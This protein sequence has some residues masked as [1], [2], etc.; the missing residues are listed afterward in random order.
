VYTFHST[1][2]RSVVC[3]FVLNTFTH[4]YIHIYIQVCLYT[5][6]HTCIRI[7]TR[8]HTYIYIFTCIYI[9][10]YTHTHTHTHTYI[11]TYIHR[12][13]HI[14]LDVR[15]SILIH[16]IQVPAAFEYLQ[17]Y[18]GSLANLIRLA[19]SL[20][21][22]TLAGKPCRGIYIRD[23]EEASRVLQ[24]SVGKLDMSIYMCVCVYI[25]IV[26]CSYKYIKLHTY[27]YLCMYTFV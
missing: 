6:I 20:P 21:Q 26:I 25:Y 12:C 22:R 7:H 8:I 15:S 18:N 13:I 9:Y 10:T 1:I 11:H 24:T 23:A 3:G 5:Y 19:V 2:F 4:A 14:H 27:M 16:N 17:K